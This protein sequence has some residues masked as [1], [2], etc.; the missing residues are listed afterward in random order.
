MKQNFPWRT[1]CLGSALSLFAACSNSSSGG[2]NASA[3]VIDEVEP[4]DDSTTATALV[5][6]EFGG[7]NVADN[8]D[9]DFWSVTLSAGEFITVEA[10]GARLDQDTWNTAGNAPRIT[11]YD[12]DGTTP[13]IV[14]QAET[15]NWNT[16]QD[17]DVDLFRAPAAG[18]YYVGVD[19]GDALATG[20]DYL[21]SIAN[22]TVQTPLQLEAELEGV[23]G[24]NDTDATAEPIVPGTV[25]GFHVD[26]EADFY[27]FEVTAPSIVTFEMRAHRNGVWGPD[28]Y[29]DPE[30][31]LYDPTVT[32]LAS[33]DDSF[34]YDSS[35][36]YL[37]STPGTYFIEVNECCDD[38]DSGYFMEFSLVEQADLSVV[39]EVEPNDS[40]GAAQA[41]SFGDFVVGDNDGSNDDFYAITCNAGD[42][43]FI[44]TFDQGNFEGASSDVTVEIIDSLAAV[45][46][47]TLGSGLQ[48]TRTIL[49]STG[50]F[51][52][53]V[54]ALA[55][56]D[57]AFT[58]TQQAAGFEAEPNDL[59]ADAG[60][61]DAN[62]QAAGATDPAG[63]GDLFEFTGTAGVPVV[64]HCLADQSN[65]PNG[66]F[67]FDD[68]GSDME[69][70]ME[71]LDGTS[72][73][74]STSDATVGTAVGT[75]RGLTSTSLVFVPPADGTYYVQV[76][77]ASAAGGATYYY[78][79]SME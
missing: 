15:L 34:Y 40:S 18:T 33:D 68:F 16:D 79:V 9:S 25:F 54:S 77:E 39:N 24:T 74:L 66:F 31:T 37:L 27:S 13:L 56:S 41:I 42:R 8:T 64:F 70:V 2:P 14:Q 49:T 20:G 38:G 61:F 69:P 30:I 51:Y 4:N 78:V 7:G 63:E 45:V 75:H 26:D 5:V 28:T 6:G 65:S 19:V 60:T 57:Y 35:I 52:V 59:I 11:I 71:V 29:Y 10:F 1:V 55:A 67:E 76:T 46:P 58:V 17:T 48:V 32:Q 22:V 72:T 62:G 23:S 50:T 44:K 43:I 21:V 53:K 12:T 36:E 3:L 73:V 47:S